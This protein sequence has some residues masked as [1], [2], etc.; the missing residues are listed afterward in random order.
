VKPRAEQMQVEK[1]VLEKSAET[2]LEKAEECFDV[3][4]SQQILAIS[5]IRLPR[6][7]MKMPINKMHL[8]SNKTAMQIS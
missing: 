7:S 8:R 4:K 2:L 6:H 3:A 1:I 5:N